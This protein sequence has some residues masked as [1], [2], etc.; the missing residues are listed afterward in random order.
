[1]FSLKGNHLLILAFVYISL[2][3]I[4]SPDKSVPW[5]NKEWKCRRQLAV[6]DDYYKSSRTDV[7]FVKFYDYGRLTPDAHDI[8][9]L[10]S[11]GRRVPS[12]VM[13]YHPD[14]Y[15]IVEFRRSSSEH[16]YWLYYGNPDAR[17]ISF[18]WKPRAGVF[19]TTYRKQGSGAHNWRQMRRIFKR[20]YP[21]PYGAGYR[22]KIF[23]G[24]NPFG[25]SE[26]F[27]SR[28]V[29]YFSVPRDGSYRFCTASDDASFLLVN[30]E[31]VA[32]W[33][34]WHG[35]W[36]GVYGQHSGK[37]T[38][39]AG[40]HKLSY[41]HLQ[42]GDKTVCVAGW[43][44]PGERHV[45]LIT[46]DFFVPVM[47]TTCVR[48]EILEQPIAPDFQVEQ[49]DTLQKDGQ[50]YVLF[51]F[52]DTTPTA[53]DS[54]VRRRWDFG[55]GISTYEQNP[56]HL[57][58]SEGK[59]T[60]K[61]HYILKDD[62]GAK[63][64][65]RGILAGQTAASRRQ[66][67]V[68]SQ[69]K[70]QHRRIITATQPLC[71]YANPF[72]TK[73][74]PFILQGRFVKWIQ[75][76]PLS[77]LSNPDLCAAVKLLISDSRYATALK[78][79]NERIK[80]IRAISTPEEVESVL[81]LAQIYAENLNEPQKAK[82]ILTGWLSKSGGGKQLSSVR[83]SLFLYLGRLQLEKL[84][85]PKD[86]LET[87]MRL[88][89]SESDLNSDQKHD[90]YIAIGDTYLALDSPAKARPY[91]EKAEVIS[92]ADDKQ[93]ASF[94]KSSYALTVESYIR[95][96][97]YKDAE[98]TIKEW[99]SRYPTE[100]IEGHPALLHAKLLRAKR[101]YAASNRL[102]TRLV[103]FHP[104]SN[105]TREALYLKGTNYIALKKY[106]EAAH[107]F[108][109]ILNQYEDPLARSELEAKL[110]YCQMHLSNAKDKK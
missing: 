33:P 19:L 50:N 61:L 8:R 91:Y 103:K 4:A 47:R 54:L 90:L 6:E 20:S 17:R 63:N 82:D 105:L 71:V 40:I 42:G 78:A 30:D 97:K 110:K 26:N 39:H 41:Y 108:R 59:H 85:C 46:K 12:N 31:L 80:R 70:P 92:S 45:A 109:Q 18:S 52:T 53:S 56:A 49:L 9:I 58:L 67:G 95:S 51:R 3:C 107:I 37:I 104:S 60:V 101:D 77:S 14:I 102:L 64:E 44:P 73:T 43:Q 24:F 86:A 69:V 75:S 11:K 66:P 35:A 13:F 21:H 10:D 99:E 94:Y 65:S 74:D 28:Y 62:G 76:Y 93:P 83:A 7:A 96:R 88:P 106:A 15:C 55:D 98:K 1:M 100:K 5:W 29:A 72:L 81:L 32:Q 16:Y 38:L 57:Y 34:G 25:L 48:Y 84:E 79:L 22:D 89:D 36:G 2:T 68:S 23:D 87:L 27:V